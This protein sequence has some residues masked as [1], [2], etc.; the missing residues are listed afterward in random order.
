MINCLLISSSSPAKI[1]S[2]SLITEWEK[3]NNSI[4]WIDLE[5]IDKNQEKEILT[6]F[7]CHSLAISDA[8]RDR[9]PPKVELF[10][11]Y[12]FLLYR[13]FV[14]KNDNINFD[15]LQISM[16]IGQRVLITCHAESSVAINSLFNI[17]SEK[18]LARSPFCR[19]FS[20]ADSRAR[21]DTARGRCA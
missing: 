2:Q 10:D 14:A 9:H 6:Q 21:P 4:L 20:A 17:Q 1:G 5:N 19:P 15:H 16:F 8:Q 12:I 3:D 7:G 18:Y 11:D 13:G